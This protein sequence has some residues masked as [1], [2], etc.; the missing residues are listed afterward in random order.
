MTTVIR[1]KR[2]S[3]SSLGPYRRHELLTGRIRYPVQGYSGYG[4]GRSTD[5]ADYTSAEMHADWAANRAELM[6]FWR[7]GKAEADVFPD[8]L[9]WLIGSAGTLPWAVRHLD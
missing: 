6:A 1:R 3:R 2:A 9:P 7:S 8:A 5:V 4:D